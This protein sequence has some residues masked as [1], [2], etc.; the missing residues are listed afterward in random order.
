LKTDEAR[1]KTVRWVA[2]HLHSFL[3]LFQAVDLLIRLV[4]ISETRWA[5]L[6]RVGG[7]PVDFLVAAFSAGETQIWPGDLRVVAVFLV[8][9]C[10]VFSMV[11]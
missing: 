1:L 2:A 7:N 6:Y 11:V 5:Y 9:V 10:F 4:H 3:P 8:F